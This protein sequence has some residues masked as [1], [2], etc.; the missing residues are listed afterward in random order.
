MK[1]ILRKAFSP[2]LE[3]FENGTEEYAYKKSH[4]VILI[5]MAILF[6]ILAIAVAAMAADTDS[7]GYYIPVVTFGLVSFVILVVGVLGN[8][9]AVSSIWGNKP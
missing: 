9:R 6:A 8:E 2:I 4:R 5:V 1:E 3:N 7:M